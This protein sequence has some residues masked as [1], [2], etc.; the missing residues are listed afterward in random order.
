MK[1][2]L[3]VVKYNVDYFITLDFTQP[4]PSNISA[5]LEKL[6]QDCEFKVSLGHQLRPYP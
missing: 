2:I 5:A 1:N 4:L 6:K 3:V